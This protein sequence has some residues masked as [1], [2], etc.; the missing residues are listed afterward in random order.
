MTLQ[1]SSPRLTLRSIRESDEEL[2]CELFC[3]PETMRYIGSP[4]TCAEA[5]QAF[6]GVLA[7]TQ[8]T[9][10]RALFLVMI[11]KTARQP[12]GLCSLQ[13]FDSA[14]RRTEMGVM[15][16]S[17]VRAQGIA[18]E[19]LVALIA[20]AFATLPFDEVWVRIALDHIACQRTAELIGLV[21]HTDVSPQDL[22]TN[23]R[24]WS[25]YRGTWS[26]SRIWTGGARRSQQSR[27]KRE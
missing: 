16:G 14:G 4:W 24:R 12:I 1:L 18:S 11:P 7:A 10:A 17:Q 26:W 22:A 25:A 21:Q 15:V 2:Y 27:E 13:N 8:D 23:V 19:A 9:P 3:D 20:H 5:A 6:R